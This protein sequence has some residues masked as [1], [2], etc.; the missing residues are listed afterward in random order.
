[1]IWEK[2]FTVVVILVSYPGL[3]LSLSTAHINVN[4]CTHALSRR[5][6]GLTKRSA[7]CRTQAVYLNTFVLFNCLIAWQ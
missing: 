5:P 7:H 6:M 1:M 2:W 3:G 4:L